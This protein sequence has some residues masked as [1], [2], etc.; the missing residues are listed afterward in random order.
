VIHAADQGPADDMV[1]DMV[2]AAGVSDEPELDAA[3][4]ELLAQERG[5][6]PKA[7]PAVELPPASS[8]PPSGMPE[9]AAGLEHEQS[10]KAPQRAGGWRGLFS[11]KDRRAATQFPAEQPA[12]EPARERDEQP[13]AE[14]EP[15]AV[16]EDVSARAPATPADAIPRTGD[17]WFDRALSGLDEVGEPYEASRRSTAPE[18][19]R[20]EDVAR[21]AMDVHPPAPQNEP[22]GGVPPSEPAVIGRY[23]SGNTTYVMFADGSIEAE[24]PN[25][26][27]HFASLADLKVYVEGGQ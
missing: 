23:T 25:G 6:S 24:T 18:T 7:A 12:I 14:P 13:A 4:E 16:A 10:G 5:R 9:P 22:A 8:E 3:I 27:L 15:A 20:H 26:V 19:P 2:K 11:R 1:D 21:S 17:D